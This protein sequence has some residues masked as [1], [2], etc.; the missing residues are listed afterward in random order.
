M[1]DHQCFPHVV[2]MCTDTHFLSPSQPRSHVQ[3]EWSVNQIRHPQC[4]RGKE[5][6]PNNGEIKRRKGKKKEGEGG[7]EE[8]EWTR[9]IVRPR[10]SSPQKQ[11]QLWVRTHSEE[12]LAGT[13]PL[14]HTTTVTTTTPAEKEL[15]LQFSGTWH[16]PWYLSCASGALAWFP[17]L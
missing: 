1:K 15:W 11:K 13:H 2:R 14:R 5:C 6:A 10:E 16:S 17:V 8:E 12:R 3:T 7:E 4:F 9:G